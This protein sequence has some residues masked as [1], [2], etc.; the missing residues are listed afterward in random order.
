MNNKYNYLKLISGIIISLIMVIL[1]AC[2]GATAPE[3]KT[4][5]LLVRDYC[6]DGDTFVVSP[7]EDTDGFKITDEMYIEKI[8]E[9]L[10]SGDFICAGDKIEISY[11]GTR[12]ESIGK[13]F[14]NIS[15]LKITECHTDT[16]PNRIALLIDGCINEDGTYEI[17]MDSVRYKY[18]YRLILKAGYSGS[19][20]YSHSVFIAY[21][22]DEDITFDELFWSMYGESMSDRIFPDRAKV[23]AVTYYN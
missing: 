22:N 2:G 7:T 4:I 13:V 21:S 9:L 17:E 12:D 11:T 15:I 14:D 23:I 19:P 10:N 8:A 18:K 5:E 20:N 1:T 3:E 6:S 16:F